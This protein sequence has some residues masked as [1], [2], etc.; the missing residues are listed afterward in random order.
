M[1]HAHESKIRDEC[2]IDRKQSGSL[3][4]LTHA[5]S[6]ISQVGSAWQRLRRS[7]TVDTIMNPDL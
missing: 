3:D 2:Y 4:H 5:R 7:F 1:S 6:L